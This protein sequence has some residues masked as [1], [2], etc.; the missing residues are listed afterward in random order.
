MYIRCIYDL[1]GREITQYTVIYGEACRASLAK[2]DTLFTHLYIYTVYIR[3]IWQGNH[4]I[5]GHI[6]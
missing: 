4:Q 6:R 1:F 5:Y 2:S 3:F